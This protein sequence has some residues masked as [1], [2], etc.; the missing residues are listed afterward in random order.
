MIAGRLAQPGVALGIEL[1]RLLVLLHRHVLVVVRH[2]LPAP[3]GDVLAGL[4]IDG[5]LDVDVRHV[6]ALGRAREGRLDR[7]DHDA[8]IDAL[9]VRHRLD[10][11]QDLLRHLLT[12]PGRDWPCGPAREE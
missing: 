8:R 7:F 1:E 6:A 3:M 4:A 5:Y 2:H 12:P 9:L 10:D 11:G